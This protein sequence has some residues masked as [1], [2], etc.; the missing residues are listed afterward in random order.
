[1]M[2]GTLAHYYDALVKDEDAS[3][4]WVAFIEQHV[5]KGKVLEL[6]CGSGE[7]TIALAKK[8]YE[9]HAS[10]LSAEMIKVAKQKPSA[11]IVEWNVMDM[12]NMAMQECYDGIL[13][14]C[15]SFNYLLKNSEVENNESQRIKSVFRKRRSRVR[16]IC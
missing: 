10:D 3:M 7:I 13:C 16:G 5:K 14:L 9:M 4:A 15:D 11:D 8:G 1:M 12:R 6:A 2:Y